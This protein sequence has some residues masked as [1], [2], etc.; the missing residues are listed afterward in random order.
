LIQNAL[1]LITSDRAMGERTLGGAQL[2]DA[3]RESG[4]RRKG[5]ELDRGAG[6]Q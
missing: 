3:K 2:H 1:M 4:H 5:M 6:R